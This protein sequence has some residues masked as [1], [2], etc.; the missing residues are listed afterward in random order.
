MGGKWQF[1]LPYGR[2]H[3]NK[4]FLGTFVLEIRQ[5][6]HPE[7][8]ARRLWLFHSEEYPI[9]A[10]RKELSATNLTHPAHYKVVK[11]STLS[12]AV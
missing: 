7:S 8:N 1:G 5:S 4:L 3:F 6:P 2:E 12:V 10:V 9:D 11:K